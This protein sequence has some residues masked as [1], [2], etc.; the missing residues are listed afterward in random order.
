MKLRKM[1]VIVR[2]ATFGRPG[3]RAAVVE[4]GVE[5]DKN[6]LSVFFCVHQL[7][8][9]CPGGFLPGRVSSGY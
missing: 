4:A 2:E 3:P 6:L 9:A 1:V 7:S 8:R 5:I